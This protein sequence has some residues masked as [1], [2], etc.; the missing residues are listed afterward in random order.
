MGCGVSSVLIS[1]WSLLE[2]LWW[3][4]LSIWSLGGLDG[5]KVAEVESLQD[6]K[7]LFVPNSFD[8]L[9]ALWALDRVDSRLEEQVFQE[10]QLLVR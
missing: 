5:K 10:L 1:I 3:S 7:V 6:V 2:I 8:S 4:C 9:L